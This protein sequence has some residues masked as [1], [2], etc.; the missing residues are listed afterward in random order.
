M[1][2]MYSIYFFFQ[3]S[4]SLMCASEKRLTLTACLFNSQGCSRRVEFTFSPS[5]GVCNHLFWPLS[6]TER[7]RPDVLLHGGCSCLC[8]F[9][10]NITLYLCLTLVV[11]CPLCVLV[12]VSQSCIMPFDLFRWI[13]HV[14]STSPHECCL[15]RNLL[16]LYLPGFCFLLQ[17]CFGAKRLFMFS[18]W[19]F[20]FDLSFTKTAGDVTCAD[21]SCQISPLSRHRPFYYVMVII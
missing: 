6:V 5:S 16:V 18:P 14:L 15:S 9:E 1:L 11:F 10:Y 4:Q 2:Y 13:I 8:Y 21:A 7:E 17:Q 3:R 12:L 20:C 19:G